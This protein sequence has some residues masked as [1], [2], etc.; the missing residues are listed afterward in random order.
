MAGGLL[1]VAIMLVSSV[2]VIGRG[3]SQF[4][5][6]GLGH[7]WGDRAARL[8]GGGVRISS[9]LPAQARQCAGRG[10]HQN[11]PCATVHVRPCRQLAVSGARFRAALQLGR[12]TAE[13]P[14]DTTMV[15]RIPGWAYAAALVFAWLFVIVTAYT[16]ARSVMEIGTDRSIGPRPS[17]EH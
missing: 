11:L 2:S 10:F 15:L 1:L 8:C 12:G 14:H 17:G 4:W 16:V 5:S 13:V 9:A 3:L 6:E 7:T